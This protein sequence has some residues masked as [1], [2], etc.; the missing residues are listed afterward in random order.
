MRFGGGRFW[1]LFALVQK[2]IR[3]QGEAPDSDF[4]GKSNEF[5]K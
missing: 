4:K 1:L 2:V 5:S 3:V